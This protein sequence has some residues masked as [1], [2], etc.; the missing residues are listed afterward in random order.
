MKKIATISK[1]LLIFVL[2]IGWLFSG[3]PR[4]PFINLP[5]E[6]PEAEA[7]VAFRAAGVV[8][9][10][11]TGSITLAAPTGTAATDVVLA[12]I[13]GDFGTGVITPPT[14][15]T[16]AVRTDS[17]SAQ[18]QAV[19]RALGNAAFTAW[20]I[21]VPTDG[22][23]GFTLA[24][25][26][27]DNTTPMDVTAAGQINASGTGGTC[28]SIT[29]VTANALGVCFFGFLS[30]ST[31]T[32]TAPLVHRQSG[33]FSTG[34]NFDVSVDGAD[35]PQTTAGATGTHT[36]T[37]SVAA[38]N[39]GQTIALRPA[40]A[41]LT[42]TIDTPSVSFVTAITS[43]TPVS[44]STTLMVNT[45]NSTGYSI[46]VTRASTT[47]TLFNGSQTVP[48]TP[49]NNNWTAPAATSTAGPS[50]VWIS[51]TTKGLGFRIKNTGTVSNTYS[52]TWWGTDD[53]SA[54]AKYSGIAT[55]T[56]TAAQSMI[57]KTTLGAGVNENTVVEYKIDIVST[58]KSGSYISSP[59]TYTV[60]ANP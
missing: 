18:N 38:I 14:G 4:I 16:L 47:P 40:A 25:T 36:T 41:S 5:P 24:Y 46:S 28:P 2:I 58:Q 59:V 48:D 7:A 60:T 23:I 19:F 32:D 53:T 34:Q 20:T 29:T 33:S 50:A 22:A 45:T 3:W 1:F 44:T 35:F 27:V 55:S 57:A 37:A 43:G 17:A 54:N 51:G 30:A 9:N 42:F 8:A 39:I 11:T 12:V 56:A 49:N 21:P 6:I 15:W 10:T 52:S 13:Y 31:F 26:G